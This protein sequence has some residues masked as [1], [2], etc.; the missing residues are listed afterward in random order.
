MA[1]SPDGKTLASGSQ[2][3]TVRLWDL[4]MV[5]ELRTAVVA[6]EKKQ[7]R[8]EFVK[9]LAPEVTDGVRRE[10]FLKKNPEAKLTTDKPAENFKEYIWGDKLAQQHVAFYRDKLILQRFVVICISRAD[11]EKEVEKLDKRLGKPDSEVI[12]PSEKNM[13]LRH[14]WSVKE[15]GFSVSC[16]IKTGALKDETPIYYYEQTVVN[17]KAVRAAIDEDTKFEHYGLA[18]SYP[19]GWTVKA[20]DKGAFKHITADKDTNT[21]ITFM[22]FAPSVDPK[23]FAADLRNRFKMGREG[24]VIK[25]N[26]KPVK[27]TILGS[28]REGRTMEIEITED[29]KVTL[30]YHA[31]RTPKYT[32]GVLLITHSLDLDGKKAVDMIVN[33]LEESKK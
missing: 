31:F 1:Y 25:E 5:K 8:E 27:R 26:A 11:A 10:E 21:S 13:I 19:K 20:E 23:V 28:E 3:Q 15:L 32:I 4:K 22:L 6:Q 12:P 16:G 24:K 14:L 30:E 2:D 33:S 18:I 9:S 17:M 7:T 29:A